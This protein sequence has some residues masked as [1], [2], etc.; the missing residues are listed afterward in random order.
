MIALVFA[1]F[2]GCDDGDS[3]TQTS[4]TTESVTTETTTES[5]STTDS[6]KT[7]NTSNTSG[8][9]STTPVVKDETA[10]DTVPAKEDNTDSVSE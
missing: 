9:A 4:S 1:F 2:L 5:T 8:E 3:T 6:T 7:V 10:N